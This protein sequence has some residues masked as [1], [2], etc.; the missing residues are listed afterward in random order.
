[1]IQSIYGDEVQ[2]GISDLLNFI[3]FC[4]TARESFVTFAINFFVKKFFDIAQS[5]HV[6]S[7]YGNN[8]GVEYQDQLNPG[9]I[10]SQTRRKTYTDTRWTL[11]VFP[12]LKIW[13]DGIK[14]TLQYPVINFPQIS[15]FPAKKGKTI[16]LS[17]V[18]ENIGDRCPK[19]QPAQPRIL[20]VGVLKSHTLNE[21]RGEIPYP[22]PTMVMR[23]GRN[24][25]G[26]GDKKIPHVNALGAFILL[27]PPPNYCLDPRLPADA[28]ERTV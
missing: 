4:R 16:G 21:G 11:R 13:I 26:R 12:I 3:K 5:L 25:R 10:N 6:G 2:W 17:W 22:Y 24:S 9:F 20:A 7:W 18:C 14:V 28:E 15:L 27:H 19:M 1:M 23:R 8:W